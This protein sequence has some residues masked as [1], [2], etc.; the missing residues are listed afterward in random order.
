[1]NLGSK[2]LQRAAYIWCGALWIVEHCW[3]WYSTSQTSHFQFRH[4]ITVGF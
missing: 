4:Y 2:F 3:L 1:V